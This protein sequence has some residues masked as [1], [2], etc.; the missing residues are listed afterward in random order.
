MNQFVKIT[1]LLSGTCETLIH[2]RMQPVGENAVYY[3][4]YGE[5]RELRC[6]SSEARVRWLNIDGP[7]AEMV[8]LAFRYPR[9]QTA[10]YPK[11]LFDELDRI[12]ADS[13]P[14]MIRRKSCLVMEILAAMGGKDDLPH[15]NEKLIPKCLAMIRR[16]I[17]DPAFGLEALCEQFSV[18]RT[19]LTR[20]FR[21]ETH[22]SP[23][24]YILNLRLSKAIALLGG[25]DLPIMEV[26]RQCGFR[27]RP[28][29][30]RFIRRSKGMSPSEFRSGT[31]SD[32]RE[33]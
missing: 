15:L 14:E 21:R 12:M 29:F 26:A 4:L 19:T 10:R 8:M 3:T 2:D 7:C 32:Q 18:S 30:T 5:E 31:A 28:T 11:H 33:R 20:L 24:R 1:W 27:D 23:G 6:V 17:A 25:T 22:I 13:S 16:E 9:I